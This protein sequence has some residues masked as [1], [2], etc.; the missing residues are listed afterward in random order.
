[1]G[2]RDGISLAGNM[3]TLIFHPRPIVLT[4]G[5]IRREPT[6]PPAHREPNF[7]EQFDYDTLFFDAFFRSQKEI[8][9][10]APSFFN[11]LPFLRRMDITA[12]PSSRRCAFR[13]R[14][15]DRHAQ[16]RVAVPEG[17]SSM[18]L[19]SEIGQFEIEPHSNL[20][21]F[22][23]DQRV[24]FTLSKN[25]RLEWIKDWIRYHR[26]IHGATG[27]LLYD[28]QSTAYEPQE[29]LSSLSQVAGIERLCVVSWPFR[30]GP[31]GPD[32]KHFWD[33]DFCQNGAWEHARWM[34]LQRARS[35]MNADIDEL[36]VSDDGS[37]VF[38]A[39]ERSRSGIVR[40]NG[41]WVH[42]FNGRTRTASDCA[43]MRVVDFDH[44]LR[45]STSR[46]WQLFP[47][48]ENVCAPKWTVV[49][50]R[51]PDRAQWTAHR[52]KGWTGSLSINRNFSFRHFREIGNHWKYDRSGR[53]A[54]DPDRYVFDQ[55]LRSN[56]SAVQWTS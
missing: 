33:S 9:I 22:F 54:F 19:R 8:L 47:R 50:G 2:E 21:E 28:N 42:G 34:F 52:I 46:R 55:R 16:I 49:P 14:N 7:S 44:Y 40:Y 1:M 12:R 48:R 41:H 24:V 10:T 36:V 35:A 51:C 18:S 27:V 5:R 38:A 56:F 23:A 37:S 17:T 25:N 4:D 3:Q 26:D 31:Q 45:H 6:R 30:Y 32:A 15:L 39:A 29:L 43:P 20:S 53:E 11:L 13:I